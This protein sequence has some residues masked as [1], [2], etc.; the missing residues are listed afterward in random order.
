[1]TNLRLTLD[2]I[3]MTFVCAVVWVFLSIVTPGV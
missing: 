2:L 3:G 1:M